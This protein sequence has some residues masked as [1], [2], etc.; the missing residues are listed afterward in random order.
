M[1]RKRVGEKLLRMATDRFETLSTLQ[2]NKRIE[3]VNSIKIRR[4]N[5][6]KRINI[7]TELHLRPETT[8][9]LTFFRHFNSICSYLI[10]CR[11]IVAL[12]L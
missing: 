2:D 6:Y 10:D 8:V 1:D 9:G 4:W 3:V 11:Y 7:F 5:R 12:P